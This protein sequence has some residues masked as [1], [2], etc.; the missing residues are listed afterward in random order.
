[1][2]LPDCMTHA[3]S[4]Q[5][6]GLL[7]KVQNVKG[8]K[9][10]SVWLNNIVHLP[11]E[12]LFYITVVPLQREPNNVVTNTRVTMAINYAL[13][14]NKS[15]ENVTFNDVLPLKA[16]RRDAIAKLKSFWASTPAT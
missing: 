8:K 6:I 3:H 9:F 16:A 13:I 14:R 5:N 15:I 1:M 11:T 12:N 4:E 2:D 7:S 10:T